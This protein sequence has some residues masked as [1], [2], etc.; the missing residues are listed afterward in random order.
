MTASDSSSATDSRSSAAEPQPGRR[1]PLTVIAIVALLIALPVVVWL[2]LVN[3]T[4]AGLRRQAGD[5][6][7]VITGIRGFYSSE[8][9]DRV[10]SAHGT[11][12]QVTA[13]YQSIPGAIPLPAHAIA[14]TWKSNRR[15]AAEYRLSLRI[16]LPVP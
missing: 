4:D 11:A 10:L 2:D 13:N 3:I 7:A 12:T 8:V 9:I 6:N 1:E 16:R 5:D 15:K 14:G